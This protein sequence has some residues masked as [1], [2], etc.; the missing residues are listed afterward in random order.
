[1]QQITPRENFTPKIFEKVS[2][3]DKVEVRGLD[4]KVIKASTV[5]HVSPESKLLILKMGQKT[6]KFHDF[7]LVIIEGS[8]FTCMKKDVKNKLAS[9]VYVGEYSDMQPAEN[10][11]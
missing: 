7:E 1:M 6:R 9:F 11:S 5:F 10:R 8:L 4:F 3:G 2:R